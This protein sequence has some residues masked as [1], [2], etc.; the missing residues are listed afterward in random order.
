M[1]KLIYLF[2]FCCVPHHVCVIVYLELECHVSVSIAVSISVCLRQWLCLI[3]DTNFS[4]WTEEEG[5]G[6]TSYDYLS[7]Q[8]MCRY[9]FHL[10]LT[11]SPFFFA[12]S[13][14]CKYVPQDISSILGPIADFV[15]LCFPH[16]WRKFYETLFS[17][18]HQALLIL[19]AVV[20]DK[21]PI[22]TK[23]LFFFILF[24]QW[25]GGYE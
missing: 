13:F 8:S 21:I 24:L 14:S 9:A 23:W 15:L 18:A 10:A 16:L 12:L 17:F 7:L 3:Y 6:S 22:M 20:L 11:W 19:S 2:N 25:E 4:E 5:W 1:Q